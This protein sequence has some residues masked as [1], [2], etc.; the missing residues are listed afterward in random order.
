MANGTT[1]QAD[2]NSAVRTFYS[3][4]LIETSLPNL[5]FL[6]FAKKKSDLTKEPGDSVTFTKFSDISEGDE[7]VDGV[8]LTEEKLDDTDIKITVSEFGKAVS[9]S[10]KALQTGM[11]DLLDEQT[12]KLSKSYVKTLDSKLRDA[13]LTTSNELYGGGKAVSSSLTAGDVFDTTIIK[14]AV[15]A[16]ADNDTP[17]IDGEYY[18]CIATPHQ[19]RGMRDDK[20]WI[21]VQSYA[22]AQQIYRGEVGMYEGVKFIETTQMPKNTAS[23][24]LTKYGVSLATYEAIIFGENAYAFADALPVEIRDN[25]VQ[26][27]GR[28]H[29]LAWYAIFGTGLIEENNIIKLVT[30]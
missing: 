11:F 19:L 22:G 2:L 5:V 9:V 24:S 25:G 21:A 20:D 26:D 17:K 1:L 4:E 14:N 12:K 18:V 16:L 6:A 29:G 8:E 13:A 28:K 30:A 10:E 15:E 27:Y 7:L 3:K 23:E